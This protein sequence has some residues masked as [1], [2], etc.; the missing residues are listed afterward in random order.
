MPKLITTKAT[1]LSGHAEIGTVK[2]TSKAIN[3]DYF[4]TNLSP[5]NPP[6]V[7][8]IQL[9]LATT[10]VV[11]VELDDGTNTNIEYDLNG[12]VALDAGEVYTFDIVVPDGYSYNIQHETGT[13]NVD[14]QII[15]L[16]Q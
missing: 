10:S 5:L 15:E 16:A 6:A 7:H 12:G 8:R 14:C 13:Q 3:T 1:G 2:A 9:R 11:K 4:V